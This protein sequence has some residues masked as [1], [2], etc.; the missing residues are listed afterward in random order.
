MADTFLPTAEV[1]NRILK[2]RGNSEGT[3]LV[4]D[5]GLFQYLVTAAHVV[6]D[7]GAT[8]LSVFHDEKWNNYDITLVGIDE[9]YDVAVIRLPLFLER[10]PLPLELSAAGIAW[11]QTVFFLGYP[12][13]EHGL[14]SIYGNGVLPMPF[15][16]RA[17]L[18]MFGTP[19]NPQSIIL[20]GINNVGFS[21]APIVFSNNGKPKVAGIVTG[22]REEQRLIDFAYKEGQVEKAIYAQNTGLI[23]GAGSRVI[24]DLIEKN[25]IGFPFPSKPYQP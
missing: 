14:A 23:Y 1:F 22:Y 16:K 6:G 4:A 3:G 9:K 20:D 17:C 5:I 8:S 10:R 11:G 15:V 18:S 25:P 13:G 2:I 24:T 21:G 12:F 7:V 19:G